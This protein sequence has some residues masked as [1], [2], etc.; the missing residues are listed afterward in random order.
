M[1]SRE[2]R[3]IFA[4]SWEKIH[5]NSDNHLTEIGLEILV[6]LLGYASIYKK[7]SRQPRS[8]LGHRVSTSSSFAESSE[9]P[10]IPISLRQS[11]DY[12]VH[13][14]SALVWLLSVNEGVIA[15]PPIVHL[16]LNLILERNTAVHQCLKRHTKDQ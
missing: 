4:S 7:K 14:I 11:S 9:S 2:R 13:L 3:N 16:R 15:R 5:I 6:I 12:K 8:P 1:L 10:C